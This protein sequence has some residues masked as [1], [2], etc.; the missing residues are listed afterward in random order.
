MES[1]TCVNFSNILSKVAIERL[2]EVDE[3]EVVR[4]V[5][6]Y[7]YSHRN[8]TYAL[9]RI[10]RNISQIMRHCYL[11]YFHLIMSQQRL[12]R[13]LAHHQI[14]GIPMRWNGLCVV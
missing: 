4:E 11:H 8:F 6:V 10:L 5:Q 7:S 1:T 9:M 12:N 13:Y 3:Y 2:A 14:P